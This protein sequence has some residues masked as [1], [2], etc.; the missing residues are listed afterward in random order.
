[1]ISSS[2]SLESLGSL[3]ELCYPLQKLFWFRHITA[4]EIWGTGKG[5]SLRIKNLG[6]HRDSTH[7]L[8]DQ[9]LG[10]QDAHGLYEVRFIYEI[11]L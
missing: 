7:F 10:L 6:L 1:M 4:E 8:L 2:F 9:S 3:N 11:I 5:L